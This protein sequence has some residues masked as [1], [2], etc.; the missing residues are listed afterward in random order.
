M[1]GVGL[2]EGEGRQFSL[3]VSLMVTING[4]FQQFLR[5]GLYTFFKSI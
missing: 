2:R 5:M 4:N 3:Y 1:R